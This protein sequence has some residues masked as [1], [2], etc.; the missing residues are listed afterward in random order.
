MQL[1]V[2]QLSIRAEWQNAPLMLRDFSQSN[3]EKLSA[4]V[5]IGLHS[6]PHF[7]Q[8]ILA[9]LSQDINLISVSQLFS[10]G[11]K[12]FFCT[13]SCLPFACNNVKEN[14]TFR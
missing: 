6:Y 1:I 14:D 12:C 9:I 3:K 13:Y 10:S 2:R 4:S 11:T 7:H 8:S 5:A